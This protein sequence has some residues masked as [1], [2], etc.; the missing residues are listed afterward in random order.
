MMLSKVIFLCLILGLATIHPLSQGTTAPQASA[1]PR[2]DTSLSMPQEKVTA[3][4][5]ATPFPGPDLSLTFIVIASRACAAELRTVRGLDVTE[6][7]DQSRED[8]IK[9]A[10]E[11]ALGVVVYLEFRAFALSQGP[12]K[13]E[14]LTLHFTIFEPKTGKVMTTGAGYPTPSLYPLPKPRS[15]AARDERLVESAAQDAARKIL[16]KLKLRVQP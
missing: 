1:K 7:R 9:A 12:P 15:D 11:D 16:K 3:I 5:L 2:S 13:E 10:K 6:A 14:D 8:A 4:L